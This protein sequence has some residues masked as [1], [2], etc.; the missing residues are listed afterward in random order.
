MERSPLQRQESGEAV[1]PARP[2]LQVGDRE[3]T[4]IEIDPELEP[5]LE[6]RGIETE[7]IQKIIA[8]A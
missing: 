8:I 2:G 5:V 7:D 3:T 6:K 4:N 1:R